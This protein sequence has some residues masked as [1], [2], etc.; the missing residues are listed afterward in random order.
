MLQKK[1]KRGLNEGFGGGNRP[2]KTKKNRGRAP[3]KKEG[4]RGAGAGEKKNHL[5]FCKKSA[6]HIKINFQN[7]D[8]IRIEY[9]SII[10]APPPQLPH[11]NQTEK[12]A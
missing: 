7:N 3:E 9:K 5:L 8:F 6:L 4:A 2:L 12:K 11:K 10:E 1:E